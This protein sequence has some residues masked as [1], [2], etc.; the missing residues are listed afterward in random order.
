M[1]AILSRLNNTS[2]NKGYQYRKKYF[3]PKS[4]AGAAGDNIFYIKFP[5]RPLFSFMDHEAF[6]TSFNWSFRFVKDINIGRLFF[7]AT[8]STNVDVTISFEEF[9]IQIPKITPT[10][11]FGDK[12]IKLITS[13][14]K[15]KATVLDR[16]FYSINITNTNKYE[17]EFTSFK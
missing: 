6:S 4:G 8:G 12:L 1:N 2:V 13:N 10:P 5:L 17:W 16:K 11:Y 7:G 14:K 3:T 9:K 15:A